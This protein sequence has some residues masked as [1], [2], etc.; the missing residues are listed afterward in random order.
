VLA[1]RVGI[2]SV[3]SLYL[4]KKKK[5]GGKN[6]FKKFYFKMQLDK[7]YNDDC[8]NIMAQMPDDYCDLTVTSPPYNFNAGSG[9][10]TKYNNTFKDNLSQEQYFDWSVKVIISKLQ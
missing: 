8:L 6:V 4:I 5:R 2:L 7:I 1:K 10:G 3:G 9:L